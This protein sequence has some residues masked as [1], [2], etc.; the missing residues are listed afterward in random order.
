MGLL[1]VL[2]A[3]FSK[4]Q[5]IPAPAPA[6]PEI[7][8]EIT[9][10][11]QAKKDIPLSNVYIGVGDLGK[12]PDGLSIAFRKA[13]ARAMKWETGDPSWVTNFDAK[14]SDPEIRQGMIETP[15]QRRKCGYTDGV[16]GASKYDSGG[17]TKFGVAQ[18]A[19]PE[20][21]V[22]N[23]TLLE[24]QQVY[25]KGYWDPVKGDYLH[26]MVAKYVFDIGCGSGPNKAAKVLQQALGVTVDGAVGAMTIDAANKCDPK[27]LVAKMR[28]I[29]INF[30]RS[31]VANNPSQGIFLQGWLNRAND[32]DWS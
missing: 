23:L 30:Y 13:F 18:K 15:N 1:D 27:E 3:I 10:I 28:D 4:K 9:D 20:L 11:P 19:H 8:P 16:S 31:I 6:Q 32:I 7:H 5:T 21:V 25:K 14:M 24:A 29:R 12:S 2:S 22:H 26:P 17:E